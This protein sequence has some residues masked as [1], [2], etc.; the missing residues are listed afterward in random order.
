MIPEMKNEL[1]RALAQPGPNITLTRAT[2]LAL[3]QVG[4]RYDWTDLSPEAIERCRAEAMHLMD[5]F[6]D[7]QSHEGMMDERLERLKN[8][9]RQYQAIVET[10]GV[11]EAEDNL[12]AILDSIAED[13]ELA[14]AVR[15]ER[16]GGAMTDVGHFEVPNPIR[17]E[18]RQFAERMER[19]LREFD[20]VKSLDGE[21]FDTLMVRCYK[22]LQAAVGKHD[23]SDRD[24]DPAKRITSLVDA[25]NFA[26]FAL[27]L[28]DLGEPEETP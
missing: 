8:A 22:N 21:T 3:A 9:A 19:R 18:V 13:L 11:T 28:I 26:M 23:Y 16:L 6:G 15:V 24:I 25:A 2:V 1:E 10:L 4:K 12:Q 20:G 7:N 27:E 17:E 5:V 14:A